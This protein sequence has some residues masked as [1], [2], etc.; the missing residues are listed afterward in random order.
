MMSAN[1]ASIRLDGSPAKR[2]SMAL[3]IKRLTAPLHRTAEAVVE[4]ASPMSSRT[5]YSRYLARLAPFYATIEPVLHGRLSDVVPDMRDRAK[6]ARIEADLRF[7]GAAP[8]LACDVVPRVTSDAMALGV[9][10]VLEGK[11]L[12]AR[13]LL[14]QARRALGLDADHGAAF[15][16][17]YGPDT[18]R[19]WRTYRDALEAFV[20]ERGQ[21]ARVLYGAEQAFEAFTA[22]IRPLGA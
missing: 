6:L 17:G 1:A 14:E 9:A 21:R 4:A 8:D 5:A 2:G 18:G 10:Y 13:F 20:A 22:W 15:F 12:G 16:A 11:T 3:S 19:M 7:L